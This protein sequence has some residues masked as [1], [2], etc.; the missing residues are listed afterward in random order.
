MNTA[1]TTP[2][3][4]SARS[5]GFALPVA[6]FSLVIVGVLVTGGFFIARQETR[7][8]VSNAQGSSAFYLA[9]RGVTDVLDSWQAATY[10]SLAVGDSIQRADSTSEGRYDVTVTRLSDWMFFLDSRSTVTE[11]G[12]LLN[13]ASRR[14]GTFAKMRT[15]DI[16]PP[17]ALTTVDGLRLGGASE[18]NG[19]DVIP[20]PWGG[21][22]DPGDLA[23]KPGVLIDDAGNI[24]T[25]GNRYDVDGSPP[26]ES[27][28]T[29]DSDKLLTFG[30]L[31]WSDLIAMAN[32]TIP[33]GASITQT[34]PDSIAAAGG[35]ICNTSNSRNWGDPFNPTGACGSHFPIIYASGNL[36]IQSNDAGQG[37]LLV[38]GDLKLTGGYN[39]FGPVI[40]KGELQTAGTGGH[41]HGGLI[42]ANVDLDTSTVLGNAV[43]QYSSCAVTRA[44]LNNSRL[45][46][47]VPLS[48]RSWVDLSNVDYR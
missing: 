30:D 20:G 17:A 19:V 41:V 45:S 12:P 34:D 42:A 3:P 33:A 2:T 44:L 48:E 39:F 5:R 37:I 11:G 16:R 43:V 9:E 27:D 24:T 47:A 4:A 31:G 8:G 46:F 22:C 25:S 32:V 6:I 18:V 35:Y 14:I 38:E 28:P 40:V 36:G 10:S 13:G 21:V 23:D 1:M 7:I 29:L 15:L 26:I